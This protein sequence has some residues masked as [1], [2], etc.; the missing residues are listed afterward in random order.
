[1][2]G[3]LD[4][5]N[6]I[7]WHEPFF[8]GLQ[9]DL[10][11]YKQYLQFEN[12]HP[13]SKEALIVDVVV[14]KKE[15][16][17][18]IDN[19]IGRIF[20]GHNLVEFKSEKDSLSLRDYDKVMGYA[21]LYSSFDDIPMSEITVSFALTMFPR[22]LVKSLE[23]ERGLKVQD[24]GN[25][26]YFILGE[27]YPTQILESKNLSQKNLF[28]KN[29][30]SNLTTEDVVATAQAYGMLKTFDKKNVYLDRLIQ[31][32]LT[33]FEE[34]MSVSEA[35]KEL[36]FKVADRDGWLEEREKEKLI[37]VAKK[38]LSLGRP[39][40]EIVEATGLPIETVKTLA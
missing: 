35:V 25:G 28:L 31:A 10:W 21:R 40:D 27:S 1:V 32:N 33:V 18:T 7:Y 17:I 12:E 3:A 13:L 39:T 9:L 36:F 30:R 4:E 14:V 5:Q 24:M 20:K 2:G 6:K 22:E 26:V 34:A 16:D 29:L 15:A 38:L 23:N 8:E 37:Q 19:E 11:Q